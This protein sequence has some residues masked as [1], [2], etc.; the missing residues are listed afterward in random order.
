MSSFRKTFDVLHESAGAYV[1]GI[2]VA[3]ARSV[4]PIQASIQPVTGQDMITAPEGRRIQDMVKVYTASEL[5][6]G[7]EGTGLMPDLIVW[8]GFAYEVTSIEVRQMDVINHYRIYATRR[9][10]LTSQYKNEWVSGE[11]I[12]Q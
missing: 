3:G 9:L 11:I 7:E 8:R 12:K 4:V 6:E 1:Q 5:Q 2:F 10:K